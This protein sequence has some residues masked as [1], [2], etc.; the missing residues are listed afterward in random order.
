MRGMR[1]P[2][3]REEVRGRLQRLLEANQSGG[4]NAAAA[5]EQT[6]AAAAYTPLPQGTPG[7]EF[8]LRSRQALLLGQTVRWN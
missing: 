3:W 8:V 6:L 2:E 7:G 4:S 5:A 1:G